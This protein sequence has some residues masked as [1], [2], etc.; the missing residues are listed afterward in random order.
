MPAFQQAM[1]A[2]RATT[3]RL[4]RPWQAAFAA[5]TTS[6]PNCRRSRLFDDERAVRCRSG[7]IGRSGPSLAARR[8][9]PF[10]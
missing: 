7:R 5:G 4:W 1:A 6:L 8:S 2:R 3:R 10:V 9:A